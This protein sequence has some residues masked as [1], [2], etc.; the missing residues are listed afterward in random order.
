MIHCRICNKEEHPENWI[1]GDSMIEHQ[2]CFNCEFWRMQHKLD[3]EQRGEHNY[4]VI[5]GHHY[6]I[7]SD[8]HLKGFGGHPFTIQWNDGFTKETRNL[9][10]QGE[11]PKEWKS[12]FPDNAKFL[13]S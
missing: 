12:V 6:V 4:A 7:E 8:S 13:K 1:N 2:L 11:I 9:W 10:C 5:D 3:V